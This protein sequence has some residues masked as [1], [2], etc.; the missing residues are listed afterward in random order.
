MQQK[1]KLERVFNVGN[2]NYFKIVTHM[3]VSF[4]K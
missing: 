4:L 1:E 2:D 3:H